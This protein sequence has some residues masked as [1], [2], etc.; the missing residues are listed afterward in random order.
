MRPAIAAVLALLIVRP[1]FAQSTAAPEFEVAS[2]RQNKSLRNGIG[3][4]FEPQRMTWTN[5][6]LKVLIQESFRVKPY[7][8]TGAPAWLDVDKWDIAATTAAPTTGAQ[9][10][11]MLQTLLIRRFGLKFHRETKTLPILE[12]VIAKNGPK[13]AEHPLNGGPTGVTSPA[14]RVIGRGESIAQLAEWLSGQVEKRVIDRTGLTAKYDFDLQWKTDDAV[15]S[16]QEASLFTAIQEQLGL[17]L[18]AAKA[19][20]EL[21]VIDSVERPS[22]N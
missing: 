18:R 13:L 1:I 4:R 17:K 16:T 20:V 5:T 2:V 22:E 10:F 21:F 12:I 19:P 6:P 3:N 9:K 8:I 11:A 7:E 14:G 15:T